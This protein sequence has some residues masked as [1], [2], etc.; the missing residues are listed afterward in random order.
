[1]TTIER[2]YLGAIAIAALILAMG[3]S[4]I[5][6]WHWAIV[7][8]AAALFWWLGE[9]QR[10]W[11][12]APDAGLVAFVAAAAAGYWLGL[13]L[14]AMLAVII[15]ALSA[16]DLNRFHQRVK[17]SQGDDAIHSLEQHHLRRLIY[18]MAASLVL[19]ALSLVLELQFNFAVAFALGLV[20]AFGLSRLLVYLARADQ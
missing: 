6:L 15:L 14:L 19:A 17:P 18:A 4:L 20:M 2:L 8:V 12:W 3:F 16:W 11:L 10:G 5:G 13:P 1:M 9:R 7:F